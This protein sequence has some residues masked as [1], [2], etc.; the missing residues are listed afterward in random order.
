ML[1]PIEWISGAVVGVA[2]GIA[3]TVVF[4]PT[5][6]SVATPEGWSEDT[7]EYCKQIMEDL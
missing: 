4:F 5:V 1:K 3:I 7:V 6:R 2:I